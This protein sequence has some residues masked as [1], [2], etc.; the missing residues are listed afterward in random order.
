M[1]LGQAWNVFVKHE[2][3]DQLQMHLKGDSRA[4]AVVCCKHGHLGYR[5]Q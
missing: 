1:Y 4:H 3:M 5:F 2:L